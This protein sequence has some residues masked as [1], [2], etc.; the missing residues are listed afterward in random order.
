MVAGGR[1]LPV[2]S[3]SGPIAFLPRKKKAAQ[4]FAVNITKM[5]GCLC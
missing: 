4:F 2:N 3:V 5:T 1:M